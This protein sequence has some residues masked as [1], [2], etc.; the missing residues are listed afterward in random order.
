MDASL[1]GVELHDRYQDKKLV[2]VLARFNKAELDA[3]LLARLESL[4]AEVFDRIEEAQGH[5]A[6]GDGVNTLAAALRAVVARRN[7]FGMP[8]EVD[9][10]QAD[11]VIEG[12]VR[13]AAGLIRLESD[14]ALEG[15]S[16]DRFDRINARHQQQPASDGCAG[17][18]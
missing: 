9:G 3:L 4:K 11:A 6:K 8:V 17:S 16:G 2:Y 10:K 13:A 5:L 7:L 15:T 14:E 12:L 1:E 18:F